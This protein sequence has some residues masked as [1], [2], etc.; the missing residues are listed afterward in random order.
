MWRGAVAAQPSLCPRSA[1]RTSGSGSSAPQCGYLPGVRL[2]FLTTLARSEGR[3]QNNNNKKSII[4]Y[5]K[6]TRCLYEEQILPK[7][8]WI[9]EDIVIFTLAELVLHKKYTACVYM[10]ASV[11]FYLLD[12]FLT[13]VHLSILYK[14]ICVSKQQETSGD[15]RNSMLRLTCRVIQDRVIKNDLY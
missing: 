9:F 2:T 3:H 7:Q 8:N 14:R 12:D 5:S 15:K 10:C 4:P 13:R 11:C 1:R 6:I